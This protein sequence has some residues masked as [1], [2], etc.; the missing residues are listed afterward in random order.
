MSGLETET[1]LQCSN[2]TDEKSSIL[3]CHQSW[4]FGKPRTRRSGMPEIRASETINRNEPLF[5]ANDAA[6]GQCEHEWN[7]VDGGQLLL[8]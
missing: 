8:G 6:A 1:N 5:R 4:Q 2:I 7:L 3:K